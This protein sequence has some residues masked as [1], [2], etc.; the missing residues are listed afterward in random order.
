MD[1]KKR[2]RIFVSITIITSSFKNQNMSHELRL[3]KMLQN[4]F[5]SFL[6]DPKDYEREKIIGKGGYAEV[7]LATN[8]KNG[9]KVALKQLY[10]S[11]TVKQA[12]SF[13]REI[14]TMLYGHHPFFLK[15]LG[16]SATSPLILIS[17]YMPNRSLFHFLKSKHR[18][19]KLTG[20]HR[21]LIAMGISHAMWY[22][23][24][25]GIIH[26]DLKSMN[27]LLNSDFSP[28]LCDFGI[29]RFLSSDP[30]DVMTTR[31]G[32]PHWMAPEILNDQKY[33]FPADV[34]SYSML[35]YEMLTNSIPWLGK[36]PATILKLVCTDHARPKFL[37]DDEEDEDSNSKE[38]RRK[39]KISIKQLAKLCWAQSPDDRPTFQKIY[40]LFKT[41]QVFFIGTDLKKVDELDQKLSLFMSKSKGTNNNKNKNS[42][43]SFDVDYSEDEKFSSPITKNTTTENN[44]DDY[45]SYDD[46]YDD[47]SFVV[48]K[49]QLISRQKSRNVP[50]KASKLKAM[51][52]EVIYDDSTA[53]DDTNSQIIKQDSNS[54]SSISAEQSNERSSFRNKRGRKYSEYS[55]YANEKIRDSQRKNQINFDN[56][57]SIENFSTFSNELKKIPTMI[58]IKQLNLFFST[59]SDY[60]DE[61]IDEDA[62][63]LILT[64]IRSILS[65]NSIE[66]NDDSLSIDPSSAF[67]NAVIDCILQFDIHQK[68][69]FK[70]SE[71]MEIS[72]EILLILFKNRS[73]AFQNDF[74]KQMNFIIKK[75]P[76]KAVILLA[77]FASAYLSSSAT[78]KKGN[79]N[80]KH[81]YLNSWTLLDLLI[82]RSNDFFKGK[83]GIELISLLFNLC[84]YSNEYKENRLESCIKVFQNGSKLDISQ[85]D[86]IAISYNCLSYFSFEIEDIEF[87][88]SDLTFILKEASKPST[89]RMILYILL[90]LK[91]ISRKEKKNL[92]QVLL[93][94]AKTFPEANLCLIRL[95]S[96]E[97]GANVLMEDLSWISMNLPTIKDT[98]SLFLAVFYQIDNRKIL[99][100][101][102]HA[103]SMLNNLLTLQNGS[104]I[105]GNS[106]ILTIVSILFNSF[107][108]LPIELFDLFT[109][110]GVFTSIVDAAISAKSFAS[111]K[112]AIEIMVSSS[113]E[114]F[115]DEFLRLFDII[116]KKILKWPKLIPRIIQAFTTLSEYQQC[117]SKIKSLKLDKI[118]QENFGIDSKYY[119]MASK[120]ASSLR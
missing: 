114:K 72:L 89:I 84:I 101:S 57:K 33:G 102:K 59:I 103:S 41:K 9:E 22:L 18:R 61:E 93:G 79:K 94:I 49:S 32:T 23:H 113:G 63:E 53:H 28:R 31:I 47:S 58:S 37:R 96:K 104:E 29:A 100:K 24:S 87:E 85:E 67:R 6:I 77:Y 16:F 62:M 11:I 8:K 68:I 55:S 81:N 51:T 20:T 39:P 13:A 26:R 14:K 119:K 116:S 75:N 65:N 86:T 50:I 98:L 66:N 97:D 92:I 107:G 60:F 44:D 5:P 110:R 105:D 71:L 52:A 83:S 48:G 1:V 42:S 120:L 64:T 54:I 21:T 108:N 15:F 46:D 12:R 30:D 38:E 88:I 95:C 76:S 74:E 109:R 106:E 25:L 80:T 69:I 90:K 2:I 82:K 70:S 27:I 7:W 34:Y 19:S 45:S 99:L 78:P 17:E 4:E 91:R 73:V 3:L 43:I 36:D 115:N 35:L 118:I 117:A 111:L 10:H 40:E 56:L 112:A